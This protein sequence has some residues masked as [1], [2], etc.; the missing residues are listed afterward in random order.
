MAHLR[1][2]PCRWALVEYS[3]RADRLMR[4]DD[5]IMHFLRKFIYLFVFENKNYKLL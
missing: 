2:G 5:L 3:R 1:Y 4:D